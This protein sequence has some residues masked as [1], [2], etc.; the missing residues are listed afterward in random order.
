MYYRQSDTWY[1]E[2]HLPI[3]D[4]KYNQD[5]YVEMQN[6]I[7]N[8]YSEIQN[9]NTHQTITQT[10][11]KEDRYV[12]EQYVSVCICC[13]FM[14]F[15]ALIIIIYNTVDFAG[16]LNMC[17]KHDNTPVKGTV[18]FSNNSLVIFEYE[19]VYNKYY[20]FNITCGVNTNSKPYLVGY[21]KQLYLSDTKDDCSLSKYKCIKKDIDSFEKFLISTL[22]SIILF[23]FILPV[24]IYI[25]SCCEKIR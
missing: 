25:A 8:N 21:K 23:M 4:N 2:I 20:T 15:F 12:F 10:D 11:E 24:V 7:Y 19:F 17:I 6:N 1:D 9:V 13:V 22:M 18:I 5:N 14:F 3:K 16:T